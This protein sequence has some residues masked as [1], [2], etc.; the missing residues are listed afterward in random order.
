MTVESPGCVRKLAKEQRAVAPYA[1]YSPP[2][3]P[4]AAI[5]ES[6]GSRYQDMI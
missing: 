4:N 3:D 1:R 6:L 2:A 5:D